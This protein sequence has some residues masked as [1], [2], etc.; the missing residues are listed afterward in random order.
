M[1]KKLSLG[2]LVE[3][4]K[5]LLGVI[6]AAQQIDPNQS[7]YNYDGVTVAMLAGSGDKPVRNRV[8]IYEKWHRMLGHPIISTAIRS[9][10]TQ[11][12]GGHET[13]GD[14]IFMEA[15]SGA[16]AAEQ[17]LIKEIAADLL[18]LFN[19][20]AHTLAFRAAGFGDG[21]LRIIFQPGK[22]VTDLYGGEMI[23]PPLIQPY[24]RGNT[25]TGFV[26]TTGE[27]ASQRLTVKQMVRCKM[28]RMTY[29][30]QVRAQELA[31]RLSLIED[32]EQKW[33]HMPALV[34]GSFLDAAE[35]PHD[36]LQTSLAGLVANRILGSI[37]ESLVTMNMEGM[38][39]EQQTKAVSNLA[40]MLETSKRAAQAL[41]DKGEFSTQRITHVMP[42]H[43]DKAITQVQAFQG[44]AATGTISIDDIMIQ[45][46]LLAGALGMDLALLGF[47]DQL[48]GG[49]GEGGFFRTSVQAAERSDIIRTALTECWNHIV[50]VHTLERYGYCFDPGKRP[51]Q[52]NYFGA[53]SALDREQQ[54]TRERSMNA[55]AVMVQVMDQLRQ[56]GLPED[57]V[58]LLMQ[59]SM[60][61][62]EDYAKA[63]AK[64]I[65]AAKPPADPNGGFGYDDGGGGPGGPDGGP[66]NADEDDPD[67]EEPQAT[68]QPRFPKARANA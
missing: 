58:A 27:K 25:T 41:I 5:R 62:D 59:T 67:N 10:V 48:A 55:T 3:H 36:R 11:A 47:A 17:A 31:Q 20:E 57:A 49:L 51:Y 52:F 43:G 66:P 45:A 23:L 9:H 64:A 12:L 32:D 16:S 19:R 6:D 50:D 15:K 35:E 53:T 34:G 33:P 4:G 46:R 13:S 28:K 26:W 37:D 7:A 40:R 56:M 2:G 30:P 54:E 14:T 18:P 65:A 39:L 1:A 22:G 63:L 8:Q 29:V 61:L 42:V 38:T 68:P 60:S 24:E 21:Y 44:S